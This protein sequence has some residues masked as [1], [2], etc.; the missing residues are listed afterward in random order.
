MKKRNFL[1]AIILI[2]CFIWIVSLWAPNRTLDAELYSIVDMSYSEWIEKVDSLS[3][4]GV[5]DIYSCNIEKIDPI[6]S[7]TF[8][9]PKTNVKCAMTIYKG[10]KTIELRSVEISPEK[11]W[12]RFNTN[13]LS[14]EDNLKYKKAFEIEIL[15]KVSKWKHKK[16]WNI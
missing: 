5:L 12:N 1:Y 3:K 9:L 8:Y 2:P 4:I 16:N 10:R 7:I 15:D 13:R 14:K 6:L 11:G